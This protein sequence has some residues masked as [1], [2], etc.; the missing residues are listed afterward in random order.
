MTTSRRTFIRNSSALAAT[1]LFFPSITKAQNL[2]SQKLKIAFIGV[3]GRGKRHVEG[4]LQEK[5]VA[6]CDV[7]EVRAAE[8]FAQHPDVPRYKDFRVMLDKIGK[9]I[10]AVTIAVPDHM[11]YPIALWALAHKKH[12]F[13]EKPLV[14]TVEEAMLLKQ[15]VK[16]SG[17]ITQMGNQGHA[18][19]GL[20]SIREWVQAG[21][22]GEVKEAYHWTD[23]PIWPQGIGEW[24]KREATPATL[25]WDL[26]LGVAPKREYVPGIAPFRWRGFKAYG[27]GAI[28]DIACHAMDASYTTFDL[29]YPTSVKSD[30]VN[31][32]KIGYPTESTIYFDFPAKG[33]RG[34]IK[35]T[36]MDGGRRPKNIPNVPDSFIQ[37]KGQANGTLLV[38]SKGAIFADMYAQYP[39][40][41]P[42]DYYRDLRRNSS[43]PAET[44][45]RVEG[46]HFKEWIASCKSGVQPGGNIADYA[47]DFTATALLGAASLGLEG[48]KLEFDEKTMKFKNS[49][50]ANS[51]LSS[52]YE[53]RKEFMVS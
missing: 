24:P 32:T 27:C 8:K 10:D 5:M 28:G 19:D 12:I 50:I 37:G 31:T 38:G 35:V 26:W 49:D 29:G 46:G 48:Q 36:W 11:H 22:I 18:N 44:L 6:F 23:R 41:F 25:D 1:S 45:P 51:R 15:A 3:G 40:I 20:R 47:A 52:E 43:L 42:L 30:S 39:R 33:N 9:D 53:Y 7:D 17:V 13:V 14:R 2:G 16:D 34:P 21:L 4:M